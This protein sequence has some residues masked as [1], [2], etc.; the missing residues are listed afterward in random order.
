MSRKAADQP[1]EATAGT[2]STPDLTTLSLLETTKGRHSPYL[3]KKRPADADFHG[4]RG[5]IQGPTEIVDPDYA[6]DIPH[7]IMPERSR[8]KHTDSRLFD[9]R[10]PVKG[11]ASPFQSTP[12]PSSEWS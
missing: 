1:S 12:E 2:G 11:S 8:P 7:T 10:Q 5:K 3:G 9:P 6:R 4:R